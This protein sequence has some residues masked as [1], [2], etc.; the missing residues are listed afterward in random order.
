MVMKIAIRNE[1]CDVSLKQTRQEI[2]VLQLQ[3]CPPALLRVDIPIAIWLKI[4]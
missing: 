4:G 1:L 2:S 3:L